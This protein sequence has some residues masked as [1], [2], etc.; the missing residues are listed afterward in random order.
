MR[1]PASNEIT[2]A[3]VLRC[4]TAVCF[5]HDHEIGTKVWLPNVHY[6]LPDENLKSVKSPLHPEVGLI[7]SRLL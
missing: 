4:E 6:T 7:C 2:S 1:R 5:L 3:A